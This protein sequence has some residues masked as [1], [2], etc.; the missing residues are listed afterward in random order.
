MTGI[1][2]VKPNVNHALQ[3]CRNVEPEGKISVDKQMIFYW[4]KKSLRQYVAKKAK[5]MGVQG[6]STILRK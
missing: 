5:E 1:Y 6:T 4:D 2:T 3:A